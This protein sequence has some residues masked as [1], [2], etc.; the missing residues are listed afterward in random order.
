[1][2][3]FGKKLALAVTFLILGLAGAGYWWYTRHPVLVVYVDSAMAEK[4]NRAAFLRVYQEAGVR[5]IEMIVGEPVEP[6]G[7]YGTEVRIALKL[8]P[9]W[10][11]KVDKELRD[12][13]STGPGY[14]DR[15]TGIAYLPEIRKFMTKHRRKFQEAGLLDWDHME[16]CMITNTAVHEG[17]HAITQ[18]TSHNARDVDSV[19]YLDPGRAVLNFCASEM[20]FTAGHRDRLEDMFSPKYP[21]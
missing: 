15:R 1:M 11:P 16:R 3:S 9:G 4:L 20:R 8:S 12:K 18:S 6:L 10:N 7:E 5:R 14:T 13:G 17:W 2:T 21:W 19:M